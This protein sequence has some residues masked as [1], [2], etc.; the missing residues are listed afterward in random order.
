[1]HHEKANT[2][3]HQGQIRGQ[4]SSVES[5]DEHLLMWR[6]SMVREETCV[7]YELHHGGAVH[8]Q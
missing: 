3:T 8:T 4:A 7:D 6:S 2:P 5:C 1:M